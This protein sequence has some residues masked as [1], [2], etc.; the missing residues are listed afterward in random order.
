M[1]NVICLDN[2]NKSFNT[3]NG[4]IEVLKDISFQIKEGEFIAIVGNSGCGKSTLLSVIAKLIPYSS[5]KLTYNLD[6]PIIGY[7]LQEDALFDHL[8]IKEN[9]LLGL[10]MLKKNSKE[11]I[12]DAM[13]LLKKYNLE[14]FKDK[15]PRELSGGMRQRVALIRTLAIKPDILFLDEPFSALDF[16]TRLKVADDVYKIIKS[17]GKTTIMVTHDIGEAIS[18][19]NRVIVLSKRPSSI[20]NIYEIE[21]NK[22][23]IP[24]INRKDD[25]FYY[26]YDKIWEDLDTIVE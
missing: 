21:L 17:Y 8:T 19:A 13:E 10:K 6:N 12:D 18:M 5:G 9:I 25:R 16:T 26:Y 15:Y 7:M 4:E 24:T 22:K 20:K 3:I 1:N 11:Y 14:Q 23:D 2:I